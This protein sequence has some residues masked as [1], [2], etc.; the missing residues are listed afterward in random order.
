MDESD[1][2]TIAERE[3]RAAEAAREWAEQQRAKARTQFTTPS[4]IGPDRGTTPHVP[5][6]VE[7]DHDDLEIVVPVRTGP[8]IPDT[9]HWSEKARPRA[10]AGTVLV[11][12]LAGVVTGLALTI[13]TQSV[14]AITLLA[15][16]AIV[17]VIFR[18]ALM[19]VGVTTIDLKGPVLRIRKGGVLDVVNLADP[20]HPIDLVGSPDEPT[21]RLRIEAVDGRLIEIT[22]LVADAHELDRIVRHYQEIAERK[23]QERQERFS[24]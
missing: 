17:A 7:P 13:T 20:M 2:G 10:V 6:Q 5:E 16:S 22:P 3:A 14:P 21:W 19:G 18:G 4:W 15:A 24:R 1:G 8:P 9:A 23:R 11:L 12:A